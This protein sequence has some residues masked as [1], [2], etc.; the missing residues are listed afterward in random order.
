MGNEKIFRR[1]FMFY[2]K[3]KHRK[4]QKKKKKK[5]TTLLNVHSIIFVDPSIHIFLC[6]FSAAIFF[7]K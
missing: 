5:T 6:T 1:N 4:N 3:Q 7:D 2:Q